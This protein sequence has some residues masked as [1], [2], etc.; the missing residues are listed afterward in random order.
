VL[1]LFGVE[2][3]FKGAPEK[4]RKPASSPAPGW[5]RSQ[6]EAHE[7]YQKRLARAK[8]VRARAEEE[9][10]ARAKAEE[11]ARAKAEEEPPAG[12]EAG[13]PAKPAAAPG[14]VEPSRFDREIV[15]TAIAYDA[16]DP[17]ARFAVIGDRAYREGE[18]VGGWLVRA[19][20]RDRVVLEG[21]E[22]LELPLR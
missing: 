3:A 8:A 16:D 15:L 20:E 21:E 10:R 22:R 17:D 12:G 4:A 1:I 6:R 9:A 19:V 14:L 18:R 5:R 13:P 2:I 7:N 11:E